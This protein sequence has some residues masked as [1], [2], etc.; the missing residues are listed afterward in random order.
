MVQPG[1]VV[2]HDVLHLPATPEPKNAFCGRSNSSKDHPLPDRGSM[3]RTVLKF[4]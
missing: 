4:E 3:R 2:H 1:I